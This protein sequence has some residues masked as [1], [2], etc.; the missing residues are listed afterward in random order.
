MIV[1]I[2]Q[3][4]LFPRLKVLQKLA[5]ADV[6]IVLDDVQFEKRDYQNRTLLV[7]NHGQRKPSWFT[8]SVKL[9]FGQSTPI[10]IVELEDRNPVQRIEQALV[11]SYRA[12]VEFKLIRGYLIERMR[13]SEANLVEL[14]I[15]STTELLHLAGFEPKIIRSSSLNLKDVTKSS[16]LVEL[17]KQV[18]A[19]VYIADSGGSNYLEEGLFNEAGVDVLWHVW[20]TPVGTAAQKINGQV[21]NGSGLNLLA[22]SREEFVE[23]V[24]NC[25]VSRQRCWTEGK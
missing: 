21:R 9:P 24:A 23:S 4:N 15:S 8:L 13:M 22:L 1:A 5:L 14:G 10:N 12:S 6:W 16:R 18:D 11:F 20:R 7:P 2:H 19:T 17:C 25:S 3:P